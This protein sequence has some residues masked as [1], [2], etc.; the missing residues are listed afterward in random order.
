MKYKLAALLMMISQSVFANG[1]HYCSGKITALVTRATIETTHV[2]IE[3]MTGW[4]QLGYGGGTQ[5]EMHKRQFSMLLAAYMAGKPVIL[6]FENQALTCAS[7]HTNLPIRFV[8][9]DGPVP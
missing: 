4:A 9:L 2:R 8:L 1:L 6:E 7:D 5:S 3:G